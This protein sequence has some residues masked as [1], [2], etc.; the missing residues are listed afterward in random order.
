MKKS[1]VSIAIALVVAAG[2]AHAERAAGRHSFT[3][4]RTHINANGGV[5]TRHVEQNVTANGFN[6]ATTK[7]APNGKTATRDMAVVNDAQAGTHTRTVEGTTFGG[8]TY[9]G[10]SVTTKTADGRS[11]EST[12]TNPN[13]KTSSRSV[14]VSVDK[15]AGTLTK[16]IS[17]TGPNG[18]TSTT[19]VV[20][21]RTDMQTSS[22]E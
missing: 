2:S 16:E 19:T 17:A 1:L 3:A 14:D 22:A 15:D 7:T 8:K 6:R 10:E 21:Q 18:K 5:S 11:R 13:G 12:F 9:S 4:D 20:K